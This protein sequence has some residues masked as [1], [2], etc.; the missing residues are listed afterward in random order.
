MPTNFK[1]T[2]LKIIFVSITIFFLLSLI[3][4]KAYHTYTK[5]Y[6]QK[7]NSIS[8][9]LK[10]E[11]PDI[12]DNT[13][14]KILN[15]NNPSNFLEKYNY[16]SDET[17]INANNHAFLKYLIYELILFVVFLLILIII[18]LLKENK[19]NQKLKEI[20]TLINK[21]INHEYNLNISTYNEDE[22]SLLRSD[23][24]KFTIMLKEETLNS[25]KDKQELKKSLE[26]ISHQLKTPLTS[27]LIT[28]DNLLENPSLP[29]K[30]RTI[31]IRNIK[32]DIYKINFLITSLLKLSKFDV[33][34]IE[35]H[36]E[37]IPLSTLITK[38]IS[39]VSALSDLKNINLKFNNSK[40]IYLNCDL[41]WEIEALTNILKNAIE[42][43]ETNKNVD[44]SSDTNKIFTTITIT[45]PGTISKQDLKHLFERFYTSQHSSVDS[46]GIG[47]ALSKAIIN[48]DNGTITCEVKDN[49]TSF[50]IKYPHL[51][52]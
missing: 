37:V 29:L 4:L 9:E 40:D 18:L 6:N 2:I 33:N 17:I 19:S 21:I 39:N 16:N 5:N 38:A 44:I 24:S 25:L 47:L 32:Q 52:L 43:T 15:S 51:M 13:I 36:P 48:K 8:A 7:L 20:T 12:S 28:L 41:N 11:Y 46:I 27:I 30:E 34:A 42:H 31:F 26:D 22:L 45:N 1:K 50:I 3:N 23:I 14:F 35:F 10:K 49:Q